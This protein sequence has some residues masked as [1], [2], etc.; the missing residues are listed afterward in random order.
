MVAQATDAKQRPNAS[1]ILIQRF[2]A[3]AMKNDNECANKSAE[4]L[5][6]GKNA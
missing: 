5:L 6:W 1:V 2:T 4:N 3:P